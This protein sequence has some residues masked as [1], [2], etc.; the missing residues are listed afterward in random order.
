M[1]GD[2]PFVDGRGSRLQRLDLAGVILRQGQRLGV[3]VGIG[4]VARLAAAH[5]HF[6]F[7]ANTDKGRPGGPLLL[8]V[9]SAAYV[10]AYAAPLSIHN[11]R[12]RH[13]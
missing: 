6:L 7:P 1:L 10:P 8:L 2:H 13:S 9:R 3:A 4:F 5:D 11:Q 12:V